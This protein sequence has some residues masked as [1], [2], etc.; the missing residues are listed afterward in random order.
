MVTKICETCKGKGLKVCT[1]C[2]GRTSFVCQL[3]HGFRVYGGTS[4]PTCYGEGFFTEGYSHAK[5]NFD[6]VPC[7]SCKSTPCPI[8]KGPGVVNED[9]TPLARTAKKRSKKK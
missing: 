5:E 3:C 4:C 8:C 1:G 7:L 6:P 9:G 2:S